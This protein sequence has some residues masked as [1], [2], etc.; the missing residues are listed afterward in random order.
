MEPKK[1]IYIVLIVLL[2]IILI[3]NTQVITIRFFFWHI[4]MSRVILLPLIFLLGFAGGYIFQ[5]QR[6]KKKDAQSR[7]ESNQ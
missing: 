1:I 7:P 4:T 6:K 2:L 3:Q 5:S